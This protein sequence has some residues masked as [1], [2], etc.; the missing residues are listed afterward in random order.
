MSSARVLPE[1]YPSWSLMKRNVSMN[2]KQPFGETG[3]GTIAGNFADGHGTMHWHRSVFTCPPPPSSWPCLLY[4]SFRVARQTLSRCRHPS[5]VE[6]TKVFARSCNAHWFEEEEEEEEMRRVTNPQP[7]TSPSL[8]TEQQH[9]HQQQHSRER[10]RQPVWRGGRGM[11]NA[12]AKSGKS[13]TKCRIP[14]WVLYGFNT[15]AEKDIKQIMLQSGR[16]WK[17][18]GEQCE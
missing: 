15:S 6:T 7:H 8:W 3:C 17:S 18:K 5:K 10:E 2:R 16:K 9:Q 14:L 4:F 12:T 1:P 11:L 13:I